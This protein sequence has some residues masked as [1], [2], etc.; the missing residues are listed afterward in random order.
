MILPLIFL[1]TFVF[2]ATALPPFLPDG[3]GGFWATASWTLQP[4]GP[5]VSPIPILLGKASFFLFPVGTPA[6][7][8]NVGGAFLGALSA[9][10][11]LNLLARLRPRSQP[12]PALLEL[13]EDHRWTTTLLAA[14]ALWILSPPVFRAATGGL[15]GAV[16]LF[17]PILALE[18]FLH[19]SQSPRPTRW[20]AALGAAIAG[21]LTLTLDLRWILFLPGLLALHRARPLAEA[22]APKTAVPWKMLFQR[23]LPPVAA[24]LA[25][26]AAFLL[27][28][29]VLGSFQTATPEQLAQ[30]LP[31]LMGAGLFP[32]SVQT[33]AGVGVRESIYIWLQILAWAGTPIALW[34]ARR[35]FKADR[36]RAA[37]LSL[38]WIGG[39]LVS[40]FWPG[41][42]SAFA[43]VGGLFLSLFLAWG[44]R[45]TLARW[46]GVPIFIGLLLAGLLLTGHAF[47]SARPAS[48]EIAAADIFRSLPRDSVLAWDQL[49]TAGAVT[50]AQKVE[51]LRRDIRLR[52]DPEGKNFDPS[53]T[54]PLYGESPSSLPN[55]GTTDFLPAGFVVQ[56][57][58][59]PLDDL[60]AP[61]A[62]VSLG[63]VPLLLAE[64]RP[65][66]ESL[67]VGHLRLGDAFARL[68]APDQAEEE[69]LAA[70]AVDPNNGRTA[71]ELGRLLLDYG[72]GRRAGAAFARALQDPPGSVDL[73][74]AW[75]SAKLLEGRV[76]EA[77]D[78]LRQ[79]L[80][81]EESN[82]GLR[83][84]VAEL[85]EKLAQPREA[86]AHWQVL[87]QRQPRD[88]SLLWRLTQSWMMAGELVQAHHAAE[89]YLKLDLSENEREDAVAFKNRL[90]ESIARRLQE[91]P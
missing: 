67:R 56:P 20:S 13:E 65:P 34:G 79:A 72:D 52:P 48:P 90:E 74:S 83:A 24:L 69:F 33:N 43:M 89:R 15:P 38:L 32:S 25:F 37:A 62:R 54:R 77:L 44:I 4:M 35:A 91:K 81:Q 28:W 78:L 71:A 66:A 82:E 88:K 6:F 51:G 39:L 45:E 68:A 61:I 1:A 80:R 8:M 7:R 50:Y 30:I 9:A 64:A 31:S 70:I 26:A 87:A 36:P 46:E 16:Q 59:V 85:Y 22:A 73:L 75:A 18:R 21:G 58:A 14:G 29:V 53:D 57:M 10:V 17:F 42:G 2:Y 84:R 86:A 63:R 23:V 3:I 55:E 27:P 19:W 49:G 47:L 60:P 11:A 76:T 12:G 40:A 41:T 5:A